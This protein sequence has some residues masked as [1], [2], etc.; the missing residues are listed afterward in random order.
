MTQNMALNHKISK[1]WVLARL[2]HRSD[3]PKGTADSHNSVRKSTNIE[4]TNEEDLQLSMAENPE[5][6]HPLHPST[7]LYTKHYVPSKGT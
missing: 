7:C 4:L 6:F 5:S 1:S 2:K 3:S